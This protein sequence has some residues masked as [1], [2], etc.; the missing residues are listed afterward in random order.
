ML[1]VICPWHVRTH[2]ALLRLR[3][4]DQYIY[5]HDGLLPPGRHMDPDKYD[6]G[7]MRFAEL[8]P[9]RKII[10]ALLQ[11]TSY[12]ADRPDIPESSRWG[13]GLPA[14]VSVLPQVDSYSC[15]PL[16]LLTAQCLVSGA[17]PPRGATVDV[18]R[19]RETQAYAVWRF[20][21]DARAGEI[22]HLPDEAPPTE[23]DIIS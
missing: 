12:H 15:G 17:F 11:L 20:S 2:W 10:P 3:L 5:L 4:A 18:A 13:L 16:A 22:F 7:R 23:Y 9:L 6:L 14:P 8:A 19:L 21:E 1:Q